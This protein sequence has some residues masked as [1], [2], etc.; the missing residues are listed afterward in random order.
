MSSQ[1]QQKHA[2]D[3]TRL[4]EDNARLERQLL[5][6]QGKTKRAAAKNAEMSATVAALS[7]QLVRQSVELDKRRAQVAHLQA[8]A[9]ARRRTSAAA[10]LCHLRVGGGKLELV[11]CR[12]IGDLADKANAEAGDANDPSVFEEQHDFLTWH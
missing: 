2:E 3:A 11:V 12:R 8:C 6:L 4:R 7:A 10:L 1:Q 5:K 9:G